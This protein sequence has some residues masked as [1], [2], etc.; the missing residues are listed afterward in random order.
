MNKFLL[1]L[2]KI[3]PLILKKL[4]KIDSVAISINYH[5]LS[6]IRK[7]DLYGLLPY[8]NTEFL[9]ICK[10]NMQNLSYLIFESFF[11][12]NLTR[13]KIIISI[14][15]QLIDNDNPSKDD[16]LIAFLNGHESWLYSLIALSVLNQKISDSSLDVLE[17]EIKKENA[18]LDDEIV[19]FIQL[20]NLV[21]KNRDNINYYVFLIIFND[22]TYN[23]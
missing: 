4:I 23:R 12:D 17:D 1:F 2:Y 16:L 13:N 11:S 8:L 7:K 21:Y 18:F 19:S 22:L 3:S 9:K 6:F 5:L 20:S 10:V 15:K 14:C